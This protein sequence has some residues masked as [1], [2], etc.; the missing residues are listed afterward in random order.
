MYIKSFK[1]GVY[2]YIVIYFMNIFK[3]CII[4]TK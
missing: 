1:I 4:I 2:V 3:Q